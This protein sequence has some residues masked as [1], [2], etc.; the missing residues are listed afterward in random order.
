MEAN[1]QICFTM[2]ASV[3]EATSYYMEAIEYAR[4]NK[5]EEAKAL[6]HEGEEKALECHRAHASLITAMAN[7]E[8]I[9][10][11]LLLMH[12]EDQMMNGEII[13]LLANEFIEVYDQMKR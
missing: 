7:H 11:S 5:I 2:I 6:I 3:G 12:A 4:E 8:E 1:E 10:F 13:K 9:P